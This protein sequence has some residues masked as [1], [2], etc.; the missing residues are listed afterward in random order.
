MAREAPRCPAGPCD[1]SALRFPAHFHPELGSGS[2]G[3][4]GPPREGAGPPTPGAFVVRGAVLRQRTAERA[5][6][7]RSWELR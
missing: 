7:S 6:S 4:L 5:P 3:Y 1:L 2:R